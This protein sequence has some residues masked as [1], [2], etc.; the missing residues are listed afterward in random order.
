M[1][2]LL[3]LTLGTP[4]TKIYV[5]PNVT[6][7]YTVVVTTPACTS[8]PLVI[9]VTVSFAPSAVAAVANKSVCVAGNTSFISSVTGGSNNVK[10]WQVST[11]GG[12]TYT[13]LTNGGIYAGVNSD[14]LRLTGVTAAMNGYKYRLA[15]TS[16][17][18]ASTTT[19]F[20]AA[21]TLTVNPTP[22]VV[23]SASPS[24]A[25]YPGLTTTLTAAVSPN[26]AASYMWFKDGVLIPGITGNTYSGLTVNNLGSYSV[27]VT[28]VN[29]CVGTSNTVVL[30]D[31]ANNSFFI[32]PSPNNGQFHVR[33]YNNPTGSDYGSP[34]KVVIYD[35]KGSRVYSRAYTMVGPYVDMQ[36]N[37]SNFG[38]GVYSVD[39]VDSRG[40]R[41]TTG[42]VVVL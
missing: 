25:L 37:L 9:P 3:S 41:L 40:N 24:P 1:L 14:T 11:D 8:T 2:Q 17:P 34:R 15:V 38:K 36:V 23:L 7:N 29:G 26:A 10:T 13:N 21:G 19:V 20:S 4:I 30:R 31:S 35:S 42:R 33:F 18:C 22:V 39:L 27:T 12:T 6:T 5:K 16:A 32:Y 28:D